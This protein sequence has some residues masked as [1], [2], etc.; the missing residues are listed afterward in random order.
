M[1]PSGRLAA[2]HFGWSVL[3]AADRRLVGAKVASSLTIA[4]LGIVPPLLVRSLLDTVLPGRDAAALARVVLLGVAVY[5]LLALTEVA[6]QWLE[7]RVTEGLGLALRERFFGRIVELPFG[8]FVHGRSGDLLSRM[9]VDVRVAQGL[10]RDSG[11]AVT[12]VTTFAATLGVMLWLSPTVTVWAL[13]VVAPIAVAD[14]VLSPRMARQAG[15]T[16]A[17]Y[18]TMSAHAVERANAGGAL[19]VRTLSDPVTE[20]ASFR[21]PSTAVWRSAI[22]SAVLGRCYSGVLTVSAGVGVLAVLFVGGRLAMAQQLQV[23]TLVALT[24]YATRCY[25][26]VAGMAG[27]RTR[28]LNAAVALQR[29]R[30]VIDHPDAPVPRVLTASPTAGIPAPGLTVDDVW[31]RYP[32]VSAPDPD[33]LPPLR[34]GAGPWALRGVG[35]RVAPGRKLAV[36]GESGVGKTTLGYLLAGLFRPDRGRI[37]LDGVDLGA[38]PAAQLRRRV[39]LVTQDAY[40]FGG[41]L[42]DNIRYGRPDAP[43]HE[44]VA[45]CRAAGI[46]DDVVALPD[47]YATVIGERGQ[48]LSGGQRQRVALARTLLCDCP[49]VVLDEAT[50]HLEADRD[51]DVQRALT[52]GR[53]DRVVI[54]IAHRLSSVVDADE[55]VVLGDGEI[56][57]RGRHAEL[58]EADGRYAALFRS[59]RQLV[60]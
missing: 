30:A 48:R 46:H 16:L 15:R 25:Q 49:V 43:L 12:T 23:G 40:L 44:V 55:I 6:D 60:G 39:G 14:R 3:P 33:A 11:L 10:L 28:V 35:F 24:Q 20:T 2:V 38:I 56:V 21:G 22:R 4:L 7:S 52:A 27:L 51:D 50:S 45:A 5:G 9:T 54:V 31:F 13:L 37:I 26:P 53:A 47:G 57:E 8:F 18:A 36:V 17:A 59:Q 29:V 42:V 41:T 1:S 34:D 32:A 58:T 19:V